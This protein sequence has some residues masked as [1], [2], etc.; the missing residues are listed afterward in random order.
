MSYLI[1]LGD[2]FINP[3]YAGIDLSDAVLD[4]EKEYL[5][6][7]ARV[8]A[9]GG[10]IVDE[11][12]TRAEINFIINNGMWDR[13]SAWA[14]ASFGVKIRTGTTTQID[15]IYGLSSSPDFTAV[16]V[17]PTGS[18]IISLVKGDVNKL[19]ITL[20]NGGVYLKS[21]TTSKVQSAAGIPYL[22]SARLEDRLNTDQLGMTVSFADAA[23]NK[24]L[25]RQ[26][27]IFTN[28]GSLDEAWQYFS[29]NANPPVSGSDVGSGAQSPY[30]A[31][32]PSAGVFDPVA[33]TVSGYGHG[34]LLHSEKSS[35]GKLADLSSALG[36]WHLGPADS[37]APTGQSCYGYLAN[38][39]CL[40]LASDVDAKAIS[41]RM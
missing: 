1:N 20:V 19:Q 5:A 6:Y 40:H 14:G 39:R 16:A 8:E 27:T 35:T 7:K 33:G 31:L 23:T 36:Y 2:Y 34:A 24:A 29:T 18:P 26:R 11:T 13:V 10:T 32:S 3:E 15:K 22:I 37:S 28:G 38:I 21:S 12:A 25:V 17:A 30:I 4:A 9:D 41:S